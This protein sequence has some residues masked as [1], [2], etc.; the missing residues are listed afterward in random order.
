MIECMDSRVTASVV[1]S[2]VSLI[3]S[4][5]GPLDVVRAADREIA[6]LTALRARAVAEF[7]AARPASADRRQ[8]ERGAMSAER[9]AARPEVLRPV[10]EWATAELQ[11]ALSCSERSAG[12]LLERSL[13]LVSRLP[14]VLVAL[15][16]GALHAGH[17][18]PLL[19]QVAVI[20]DD[21]PRAEIEA[22]LLGWV[23]ARAARG[24]MTT[25]AQLGDKARRVVLQRGARDA[26]ERLARAVKERGVHLRAERTEGMAAVTSVLTGPEARTL[27]AALGAYADALP[28]DPD[29]S[30]SR[31]A[32]MADCLLDLVLRPGESAHPPVQVAL[33]LVAAVSTALGGDAP[34]ELDGQVVSAETVR[35]LLRLLAGSSPVRDADAVASDAG[36][37]SPEARAGGWDAGAND[38]TAP[39]AE[40]DTAHGS[41]A[42]PCPAW[43]ADPTGLEDLE[44]DAA[45]TP[46]G[47]EAEERWWTEFERRLFADELEQ[48]DAIPDRELIA[49]ARE[50]GDPAP[51]GRTPT[52][53]PTGR[54]P[55]DGHPFE[56]GWWSAADRAVDDAS[57]AVQ[58]AQSALAHARRTVRTA[59]RADAADETAWRA[60]P[61]GRVDA[62]RNALEALAAAAEADRRALADLLTRTAGG[63]LADRPRVALVDALTGALVSLTDLPTLR[64][65]GCGARRCRRD[66]AGCSHDLSGRPGPGAPCPTAGYRPSTALDRFLRARDR[67]CRFPGCRRPVAKGE[68]DHR[69]RYPDGPT[70]ATNLAGFCV[71]HHR[72]KHQAPGWEH[73]LAPDGTLT[74]TTPT[75]LTAIT[76]PPPY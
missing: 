65:T 41:S 56:D 18:G 24:G 37:D 6:R 31:S 5:D 54:I 25:P 64:R 10:S 13:L 75:G 63:G 57:A 70:A 1:S 21:L 47:R 19:D 58:A 30:R 46:A 74:V 59:E 50:P 12:L 3:S 72:G 51:T 9:W 15:E 14:G 29:D 69:I 68:L 49:W 35:Q 22:E 4:S 76:E 61:G 26:A 28:D 71:G 45:S 67:R 32:K 17:L 36:A 23:A 38:S 40:A 34:G 2:P 55:A 48:P 8:G 43:L 66:P 52:G 62:A 16:S 7:A 42:D 44:W 39:R 53:P 11:V 27:Y 20:G 33:T 73:H 60:G